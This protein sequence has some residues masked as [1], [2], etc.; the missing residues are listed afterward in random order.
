MRRIWKARI[1]KKKK[2]GRPRK[3]WNQ[4]IAKNPGKKG[5]TKS[6]AMRMVRNRKEWKNFE[7]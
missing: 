4:V 7:M 3:I 1:E 5:I 2:K 6:E